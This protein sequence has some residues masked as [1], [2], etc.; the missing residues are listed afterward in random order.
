MLRAR[1]RGYASFVTL[2]LSNGFK[3]L[4]CRSKAGHL[5]TTDRVNRY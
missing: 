2:L 5:K 4:P 3:T 1:A